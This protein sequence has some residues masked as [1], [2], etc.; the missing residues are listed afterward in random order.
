MAKDANDALMEMNF[1]ELK[2]HAQEM[3]ISEASCLAV[4][5]QTSCPQSPQSDAF[6]CFCTWGLDILESFQAK[7]ALP[8]LQTL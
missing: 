3:G 8:N 7:S 2:Q 1:D 5:V 6:A 4:S